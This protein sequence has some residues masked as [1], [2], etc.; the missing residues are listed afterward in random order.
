MQTLLNK[1]FKKKSDRIENKST[2]SAFNSHRPSTTNRVNSRMS[3]RGEVENKQ[4]DIENYIDHKI[5]D[6]SKNQF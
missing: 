3:Q 1:D 2:R 6:L 5:S 4:L